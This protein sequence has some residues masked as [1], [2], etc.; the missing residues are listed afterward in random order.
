[1]VGNS[2]YQICVSGASKGD[3]VEQGYELAQAVGDAIARAGHSLL[4]G[5]T[6]GLPDVAAKGYKKA[7]GKMCLGISPASTKVEHVLKYRLPLEQ[8]DA[9]L[10]SGLHYVGR[11]ALLINS[12]DAVVS[13]GGRLGTLHEFTIAMETK[14]PIAFLQGAGGVSSEIQELLDITQANAEL[15]IFESD[16]VEL[17]KKL[18]NLLNQENKEYKNIYRT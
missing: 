3:S 8:Y 1:M 12:A 15:V 5:A 14:T 4:T 16:P 13:I 11:D 7:G 2:S 17:V 10:Y 9:I 18:T 6:T